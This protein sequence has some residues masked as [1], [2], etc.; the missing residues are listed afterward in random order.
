MKLKTLHSWAGILMFLTLNLHAATLYV[1]LNGANPT[2]PY[3]DWST[4]ATNI[5]DAIGATSDGD[6]VLAGTTPA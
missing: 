5:Q 6:T 4:A 2:P 1:D 3:S